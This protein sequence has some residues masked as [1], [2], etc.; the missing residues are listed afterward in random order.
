[1]GKELF[2]DAL[3]AFNSD[4]SAFLETIEKGLPVEVG[5][6]RRKYGLLLDAAYDAGIWNEGVNGNG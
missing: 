5:P 4:L 6:I 2:R 3:L 1:M